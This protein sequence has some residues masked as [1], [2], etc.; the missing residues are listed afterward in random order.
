MTSRLTVSETNNGLLCTWEYS[1][2]LFLPETIARM[3]THFD[4]LL[5]GIIQNP[6]TP[7]AELPILPEA[8]KQLLLQDLARARRQHHSPDLPARAV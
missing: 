2:D 4:T 5:Q 7:L 6:D 3:H 1:T 8:E